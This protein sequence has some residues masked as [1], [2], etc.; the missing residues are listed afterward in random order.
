[1]KRFAPYSLLAAV[2]ALSGVAAHSAI[3]DG[4]VLKRTYRAGDVERFKTTLNI[5]SGAEAG[6]Q[7]VKLEVTIIGTESVKEVRAD[8]STVLETKMEKSIVNVGGQERENPGSGEVITTIINKEGQIVPAKT[9]GS[10][11]GGNTS[12]MLAF[13]RGFAFPDKPMRAGDEHKFESKS[14]DGDK[15]T[16]TVKGV[17][18]VVGLEKRGK[19]LPADAVKVKVLVDATI[20]GPEGTEAQNIHVDGHSWIEPGEGKSVMTAGKVTGFRIPTLG[21]ATMEYKRVRIPAGAKT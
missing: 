8:G 21:N 18:T 9:T 14:M 4:F 11:G 2:T 12:Q 17:L 19:E 5:Q 10:A 6:A 20:P 13:T 7:P 16:Q 1:M 3:D 15:T